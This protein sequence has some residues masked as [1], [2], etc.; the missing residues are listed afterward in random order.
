MA[1]TSLARKLRSRNVEQRRAAA[2]DLLDTVEFFYP[3]MDRADR[4]ITDEIPALAKALSDVDATVRELA[5]QAISAA[6][7]DH[8]D[9]DSTIPA[10]IAYL[11]DTGPLEKT[12]RQTAA[13][14]L[15][16]AADDGFDFAPHLGELTG[17]LSDRH[18]GT[19][20]FAAIAL[21]H[22]YANGGN[23]VEAE[24]LLAH[25]SSMIRRESAGALEDAADTVDIS[26]IIPALSR[27]LS[28]RSV[29]VRLVAASTLTASMSRAPAGVD[30]SPA[31]QVL[32]ECLSAKQLT[33][34]YYALRHIED[35]LWHVL[36][37]RE[38]SPVRESLPPADEAALYA[39]FDEAQSDT[40]EKVRKITTVTLAQRLVHNQEFDEFRHFLQGLT[41]KSKYD[42]IFSLPCGNVISCDVDISPLLPDL[43]SIAAGRGT[44][45]RDAARRAMREFVHLWRY[46]WGRNE[47]RADLVHVQIDNTAITPSMRR[48]LHAEIKDELDWTRRL[49]QD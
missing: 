20:M 31:I 8:Q 48:I 32:I 46:P 45:V 47:E 33:R 26:P 43:V 25:A 13:A 39:A 37:S 14:L 36:H 21:T 30:F 2:Q 22:G 24:S 15:K 35:L 19:R 44:S 1:E 27:L 16:E 42:V 49:A 18:R 4:D 3:F 23:W 40:S 7:G 12:A 29:E 34:K 10:V 38:G 11:L 6:Q 5:L 41:S 9:I 28:D 17:L